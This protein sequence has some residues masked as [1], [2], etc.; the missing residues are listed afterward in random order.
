LPSVSWNQVYTVNMREVKGRSWLP[1]L[2]SSAVG[3]GDAAA[4]PIA[5]IVWEKLVRFGQI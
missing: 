1:V 4:S 5:T 2:A 3:A